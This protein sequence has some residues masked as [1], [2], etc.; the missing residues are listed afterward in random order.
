MCFP[1]LCSETNC[2][3]LLTYL[4]EILSSMIVHVYSAVRVAK[5]LRFHCSD[6]AVFNSDLSIVFVLLIV[7]RYKLFLLS[8]TFLEI[9]A[10]L[11]SP[12]LHVLHLLQSGTSLRGLLGI[13]FIMLINRTWI[14]WDRACVHWEN[15]NVYLL[16]VNE[17]H[18][19]LNSYY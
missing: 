5:Q 8:K 6:K 11:I 2:M 1:L 9:W 10:G 19:V 4:K 7:V 14:D 12:F 16:I 18:L 3:E 15:W 17:L 13:C